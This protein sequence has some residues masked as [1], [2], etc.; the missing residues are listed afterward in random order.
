MR[1]LNQYGGVV[2][3]L[4][5][6]SNHNPVLR[7]RSVLRVVSYLISSSNHNG[8][9]D[10]IGVYGLFLISYHHQTTTSLCALLYFVGCFLSH[11]IIKPQPPPFYPWG[12][13]CCFLSYIIIKPQPISCIQLIL[14]VSEYILC[15]RRKWCDEHQIFGKVI[16][17]FLI[18]LAFSVLFVLFLPKCLLFPGRNGLVKTRVCFSISEF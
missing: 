15:I 3:Y 14:K 11:I 2:S 17:I 12:N 8:A 18:A 1:R 4:I 16:K 6:S 9:N 10:V 7:R 13:G 5:S